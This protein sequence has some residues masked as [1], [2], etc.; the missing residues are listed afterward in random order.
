M[1]QIFK[2]KTLVANTGKFAY[3]VSAP[4]LIFNTG[5]QTISGTKTFVENTVFGD[6]SQG[7]FLVISGN[8]FSIYGSGNFTSG[9]FV[10]GVPVLTGSPDWYAT[11]S[12]LNSTGSILNNKIDSLSGYVDFSNN[13][14][15][16]TTGDQTINGLKDFIIRPTVNTI[17]VLLSGEKA[18]GLNLLVKNDEPFTVYKSQP[19]YING[20]AGNNILIKL[21]RNTGEDTSSKTLGLLSQDLAPNGQGYVTT[22]GQLE[23]VD[24]SAAGSA[25]DPIWL[26]PT[27]NLIFG[28]ANK[29]YGLNHLVYLGVVER[30]QANN[31]KIYVKVQ[32][33]FEIEELHNVDVNHTYPLGNNQVL[34]YNSESGLWFNLSLT[35]SDIANGNNIVYTTGNQNIDGT[36]N[37]YK[38]PTINGDG[39]LSSGQDI[40]GGDLTG[41]LLSATI[42]K[43]QGYPLSITSPTA[44]QTLIYNGETWVPGTNAGGGGGGGGLFYYFNFENYNGI[45]PSGGLPTTGYSALSLLGREYG[46]GAGEFTSPDLSPQNQYHLVTHFVSASGDPGVTNIPAGLWDF[47]IWAKTDSTIATQTQMKAVVNIYDPIN[48]TY[49]Y[50]NQSDDVYLYDTTTPAQ[51]ILNVT[52]PQTG[53]Q[54][55]ERIYVQLFGKKTTNPAKTITFYFDSYRPSHVHTTIPSIAGSGVVKIINGVYQT[56]ASTIVDVDVNPNANIQQSK[57]QNLTID[58]A[59]LNNKFSA[60]SGNLITTGSILDNK[61]NSLS[62]W[63]ASAMNLA[64]TGSTLD[65]KINLLSG[66]I[67][68]SDSNIVFTTGN[69]TIAGDKNFLNNINISGNVNVTG[70]VVARTGIFGLNN[71]ISGLWLTMAG[72]SGNII[73]ANH[74]VING[75][76]DNRLSGNFSVIGGGRS[77]FIAAGSSNDFSVIGGGFL[78]TVCAGGASYGAT[79]G[80]GCFNVA[81]D[82]ATIGGGIFNRAVGTASF[83]GGGS[84]NCA[85]GRNSFIGG[86]SSNCA[87][88]CSSVVGG[89]GNY[90]CSVGSS[91]A[92]GTINTICGGVVLADFS[93][94]GGGTNNTIGDLFPATM[95]FSTI[96]GGCGNKIFSSITAYAST[97]GGGISNCITNAGC[98][99]IAGGHRNCICSIFST[100]GGGECNCILPSAPYSY[101]A[102]GRR[103]VIQPFHSGAALLGDGQNRLHNSSGAHTLTLDF[104]SGVYFASPQIYGSLIFNSPVNAINGLRASGNSVL[105]GVDLSSYATIANLVN[106]GSILNNKINSLS[107]WSASAV[108][109]TATGSNLY[110]SIIS[111]SGLFTGYTGSLDATFATDSQLFT[112]GSILNDKINSLSGYVNSQDVIFSGQTASTGSILDSK[113]NALSG[114]ISG[115]SAGGLLPNS[116]VYITGDQIISGNK[117]FLNNISVS[118]TG[119]FNNVRVSSIDNLFLSGIDI[120]ITGNSSINI[121]NP[122]YIS[123]N[124][125]LTGIDLNSYA[126]IS[127][128]VST[129]LILD[130]KI[131]SLSGYV[132]SRDSLFSGQTASTG[133]ILDNKINTLSGL[134]A[135]YTGSLDNTFATD[136]QL[137]STG[138]TLDNKINSLSGYVNSRDILFSGQIASTGSILDNKINNLSGYI[139]TSDSNIVF[140]TGNQTIGGIKTFE[141]GN[142]DSKVIISGSD[143]F[144]YALSVIN[145]SNQGNVLFLKKG[146][147]PGGGAVSEN[148]VIKAVDRA[149]DLIFT[150]K[151]TQAGTNR[152]GFFCDPDGVNDA[153]GPNVSADSV[154]ISGRTYTIGEIDNQLQYIL[155]DSNSIQAVNPVYS[156]TGGLF[157][158]NNGLN[159]KFVDKNGNYSQLNPIEVTSGND[160]LINGNSSF[161]IYQ[162]GTLYPNGVP[163]DNSINHLTRHL[164]SLNFYYGIVSG[165]NFVSGL[166]PGNL[167]YY[168]TKNNASNNF[169]NSTK[170]R[171]KA[172]PYMVVDEAS[173]YNNSYTVN[174][175]P[176]SPGNNGNFS[177]LKFNNNSQYS[178]LAIKQLIFNPTIQNAYRSYNL[179]SGVNIEVKPK[180]IHLETF[181][182]VNVK[183]GNYWSTDNLGLSRYANNITVKKPKSFNFTQSHVLNFKLN[184]ERDDR[185]TRVANY[186]N[187]IVTIYNPG[188]IPTITITGYDF[189]F[190]QKLR[191]ILN[192][193]ESLKEW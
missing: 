77:N 88:V 133:S 134:F 29:P 125:V 103:A 164:N 1:A 120:I 162:Q 170:I 157:F 41:D 56:P 30:K 172:R 40:I 140:T 137:F 166:K 76:Q 175:S 26:G 138:S 89:F 68:S 35:S 92:G 147:N 20:A 161:G 46:A 5:N 42:N 108:D 34:K 141:V 54:D 28:T 104:A 87:V 174:T 113:I 50:V 144:D 169:G 130:N 155:S 36:K 18:A 176:V 154:V 188:T 60:V 167:L 128:L 132:N 105:T 143:A 7:D 186:P 38:T 185:V 131:N 122:I 37:F 71:N 22:E 152:A 45:A 52:M 47:N 4:N 73:T 163:S 85:A 114:Y 95:G 111:L 135:G 27:G 121:Y 145:N 179:W 49:R 74:S 168:T 149:D 189:E 24:T 129:G 177:F 192:T 15:V 123:G 107:G 65:N 67:N 110:N 97:I 43:L 173:N 146:T 44:G 156:Y 8:T 70:R 124:P 75:G 86:G 150:L 14:T 17:P 151:S 12:N 80:G 3:E 31:G 139:N 126:T 118:G 106:T 101:I 51:Y 100:I 64:S 127:N 2:A 191:L 84:T 183:S 57:I 94:I 63:S 142:G 178:G 171:A 109:L 165:T 9:L 61:I 48:S 115:I 181:I 159:L 90:A 16:F 21:A 59:D 117:T 112:T 19:V 58:L 79:I 53:I 72:G 83:I 160:V 78:N 81:S 32:N 91:I 136:A 55:Y 69:Q 119:N 11:S 102:G 25:G 184:F 148:F 10:N 190:S 13:N 82:Q 182:D 96:V 153:G 98:S 193:D 66:Y 180:N 116:I 6:S 99:I 33:G 23:G 158:D 187:R 39:I 93:F 62:G